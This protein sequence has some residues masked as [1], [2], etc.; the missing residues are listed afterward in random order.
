MINNLPL[1]SLGQQQVPILSRHAVVAVVVV[2]VR[3]L[4]KVLK[5]KSIAHHGPKSANN[6]IIDIAHLVAVGAIQSSEL[7]DRSRQP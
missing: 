7:R 2:E 3:L 1:S 5:R 4:G 6:F